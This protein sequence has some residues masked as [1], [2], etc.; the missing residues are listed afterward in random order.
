MFNIIVA[1]CKKNRGIGIN[2]KIPFYI[3]NDLKRFKSLTI[4]DGN[5][6][7]IMG[8]NTWLNS[9]FSHRP[10][11]KSENI[12]LTR[13]ENKFNLCEKI[14][15]LNNVESLKKFCKG[16]KY[17]ENWIIGGE[18]TFKSALNLGIVKK[19]YITEIDKEYEC[20]IFFPEIDYSYFE[21]NS[22]IKDEYNGIKITYK[23]F[24]KKLK[25]II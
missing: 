20:D 13:K 23:I 3:P 12:V 2:N 21:L 5:N 6:S 19:I 16:K 8:A 22:S 11:E 7:I 10:L 18:E 24:A 14:Y 25:K 15:L 17:S 1:M 4:G 9:P